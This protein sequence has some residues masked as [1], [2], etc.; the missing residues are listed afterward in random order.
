M[1]T[2]PQQPEDPAVDDFVPTDELVRR[3]GIKPVTFVYELSPADPFES[4]KEW[5]AFLADLYESRRSDIS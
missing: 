1:A 2:T 4:D 3:Q 5:A